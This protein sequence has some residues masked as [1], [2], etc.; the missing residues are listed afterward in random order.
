M[1]TFKYSPITAA[2]CTD[3]K[4]VALKAH[5]AELGNLYRQ[6]IIAQEWWDYC[7]HFAHADLGNAE[8]SLAVAQNNY[9]TFKQDSEVQ[10]SEIYT[11][12]GAT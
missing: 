3:P 7:D 9:R 5:R 10:V 11:D 8:N 12:G 6:V 4:W 1:K 2:T